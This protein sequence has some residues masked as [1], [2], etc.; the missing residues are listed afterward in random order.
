MA[1]QGSPEP[2]WF[3]QLRT[4]HLPNMRPEQ[5]RT[6]LGLLRGASRRTIAE[7]EGVEPATVKRWIET[8]SGEIAAPLD[9]EH[10]SAGELR[11]GWTV[12]HFPCCLAAEVEAGA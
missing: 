1:V 2:G 4:H 10:A 9:D 3:A 5:K 6:L 11:G 12:L 7:R 8:A